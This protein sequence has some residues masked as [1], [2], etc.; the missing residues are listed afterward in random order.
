MTVGARRGCPPGE[1][2][3]AFSLSLSS[4][5]D[6]SLWQPWFGQPWF[7]QP[8]EMGLGRRRLPHLA[9]GAELPGNK[10]TFRR[11]M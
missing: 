10:C 7:G 11:C 4:E 2:G 1:E 9:G 3:K 6:L 8:A 5:R